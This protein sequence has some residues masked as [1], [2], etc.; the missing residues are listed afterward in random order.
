[1][2]LN[3]KLKDATINFVGKNNLFLIVSSCIV[4]IGIIILCIFGMNLSID[5][6]G[7]T[8]I[9]VV[10][11]NTLETTSG[12]EQV[13]DRIETKMEVYGLSIASHQKEG[14]A[15]ESYILVKYQDLSGKTVEQMQDISANLVDDLIAEFGE[16]AKVSTADRLTATASSRL[17]WSA[18]LAVVIAC[19]LIAGYTLIRFKSLIALYGVLGILHDLLLVLA[20]SIICRIEIGS[21]FIAALITVVAYSINNNIVVFDRIRENQSKYE[22]ASNVELVNRSISSSLVRTLITTLITLIAVVSITCIGVSDI[23]NF[24]IPM[25]IGIVASLYSSTFIVSPVWAR[26]SDRKASGKKQQKDVEIITK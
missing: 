22:N 24:T 8:A 20:L 4:L 11:G 16:D 12:Y 26:I 17:I 13:L 9:K 18:V 10:A 15:S 3:K 2:S 1:M 21:V 23:I 19:I 14:D 6:T 5:F 7:G 25:I